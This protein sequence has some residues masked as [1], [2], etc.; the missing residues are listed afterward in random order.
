[1]APFR[2]TCTKGH[3]DKNSYMALELYIRVRGRDTPSP[4]IWAS[5]Y[6]KERAIMMRFVLYTMQV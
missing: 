5:K 2:T 4:I 3:A 6:S 1:M